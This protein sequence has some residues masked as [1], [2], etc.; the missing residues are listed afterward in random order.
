MILENEANKNLV[1]GI[2][3]GSTRIKGVLLDESYRPVASAS[4]RW[5]NTLINDYW[6]YRLED[7][8]TGI[9]DVIAQLGKTASLESVGAIG[10][11]AMMHG[12]LTFDSEGNQ[13]AEF[14]TWRNTS[15]ATAA[16]VLSE[17]LHFNIPLRWSIAHLYQVILDK[18]E[19]VSDISFITTLAGY[20]HYMLSGEKVLGTGDASGMF[21][22]D[23][24][25]GKYDA[26]R[27]EAFTSLAQAAGYNRPLLDIL[28]EPMLAGVCAGNLTRAGA[29]LLDPE[30][31]LAAGIPMCP[32]EGDAGTGMVATNSVVTQSGNVSAGTSIFAMVVL[33]RPLKGVYEEIDMVTTP[34]GHPVAMVHCNNCTSDIDAWIALFEDML[35]S[36][37]LHADRSLLYSSFYSAAL[38]G[39][40]DGGG[41]LSYNFVSGEPLVGL[42]E[43]RPLLLRLPDAKM[44]F[45]NLARTLIFASIATLRLGLEI[46]TVKE[47]ISLGLLTGHG[48]LF[49]Q[50]LTGQ[51]LMAG[52]L[53]IPIAV[54]ALADEGG[55]WGIGL[56]AA[57]MVQ[58]TKGYPHQTAFCY[59]NLS[60]FLSGC[61]FYSEQISVI[62]PDKADIEGFQ[63]FMTRYRKGL[64]I[65]STATECFVR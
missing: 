30:G 7:V 5:E 35:I 16:R 49:A 55:A 38:N 11:S 57:F 48:G 61:V 24:R 12:Y 59:Q 47:K 43:G 58:R 10:I 56:L 34:D 13:L 65:A 1:L 2:E 41:L 8:W 36:A 23:S 44:T 51:K 19:H 14:R 42:S 26:G 28:P 9:R 40:S 33:D 3:L 27:V 46:L 20:V 39:E 29:M 6:S 17:A 4:F 53:E 31:R 45:S 60:D 32:P 18:E 62:Q 25:N 64:A 52:A 22:I 21:P 37:G 15:T 54:T 63:A 50:P